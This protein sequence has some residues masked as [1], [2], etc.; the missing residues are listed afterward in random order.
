MG[1]NGW[2]RS[3]TTAPTNLMKWCTTTSSASC[4][5]Y[6]NH[7]QFVSATG[8]DVVAPSIVVENVAT[9]PFFVNEAA[10][11]YNLLAASKARYAGVALPADI[12]SVLGVATTP[13]DMGALVWRGKTAGPAPAP[14]TLTFYSLDDATIQQASPDANL[15]SDAQLIA[16][17]D[18]RTDFLLKFTVSGVGIRTVTK[19]TLNLYGV[20]PGAAGAQ[21]YQADHNNWLESSVTWNSAPWILTPEIATLPQIVANTTYPVDVTA[22]VKADGTYSFRILQ[23]SVEGIR[24]SSNQGAVKPSL[25]LNI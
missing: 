10:G 24:F 15:G 7:A 8:L 13:V 14:T 11:D 25:V 16:D 17:N 19:A 2:Y 3:S 4:V 22:K 18:P 9:N 1:Y 12:A 21:V 23:P 20:D 5:S 6:T